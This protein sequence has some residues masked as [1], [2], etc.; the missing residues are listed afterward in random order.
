MEA[1]RKNLMTFHCAQCHT[2]LG[3]SLSLCGELKWTAYCIMCF[4]VTQ[5]VVISEKKVSGHK[6][7]MA[8][9]IYSSLKC[10]GCCCAVGKVIHSSPPHLAALRSIFLLYKANISC[11]TLN[12]KSMVKASAVSFD[13]KPLRQSIN[14]VRQQ[15]ED[16]LNQ[17]SRIK[18]RLADRS[19]STQSSQQ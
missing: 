16:Q 9:C 6:D 11:Y 8:N 2:V 12:S 14:E 15:F 17:M 3:D 7:E 5:D 13:L 19:I 18:S 10:H 1:E 4:K